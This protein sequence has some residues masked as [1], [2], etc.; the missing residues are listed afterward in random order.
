ME[1]INGKQNS[2]ENSATQVNDIITIVG[3]PN[4]CESA[5]KMLMENIPKTIEVS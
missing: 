4:N 3:N 1:N 2:D 5:K